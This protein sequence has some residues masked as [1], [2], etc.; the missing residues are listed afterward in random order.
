M[1]QMMTFEQNGIPK[2]HNVLWYD[3]ANGYWDEPAFFEDGDGLYS[4]GS[5]EPSA[6]LMRVWS[7]ELYGT[8]FNS[9]YDFGVTGDKL[10]IGSLFS[11]PSKQVAAFMSNG[12]TDGH[13]QL[14]V[15]SGSSLN[16]VSAFGVTS[17]IPVTN[18]T[19]TLPVPELPVYVELA[20]GQTI[21]VV[22]ENLGTD[23]ALQQGVSAT[24][25]GN[26]LSPINSSYPNSISKIYNGVLEDWYYNQGNGD[27]PWMDDTPTF[28]AWVQINLPSAQ[29]IS[30]VI[31]YSGVPWQQSGSL[32]DYYLQYLGANGQWV[33]L[34]HVT[35]PTPVEDFFSPPV[36]TTVDSY[37]SDRCVFQHD[38]PMVTTSAI[39]LLVNNTTYGGAATADIVAAGGQPG[40]HNI[41]L[42]EVE[43]Y[44]PGG[45]IAT[46]PASPT[47]LVATPGNVQV[48]LNWGTVNGATS[49]NVKRST[50]S[51]GPYA[52]I[53]SPTNS[54]FTDST[55]TNG[56]E[57]Y[58]VVSAVNTG[59]ESSNSS[60]VN[61]T[62]LQP[63]TSPTA[64]TGLTASAGNASV[65]LLWTPVTSANSYNVKRSTTNGGPYTT[66]ASPTSATFTDTSVTNGTTYYYVVSAVNTSGESNNSSPVNATPAAPIVK[67]SAPTGLSATAGNATVSLIW[68]SSAGAVTYNVKR[69][70]T[71][72]GP[73]TTISSPT[74]TTYA[75]NSVTNGIPRVKALTRLKLTL[76]QP[77]L[78]PEL[79]Y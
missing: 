46:P 61:A 71:T 75:D 16:V 66:I 54:T 26:G 56:A 17:T 77:L 6:A 33:N 52:T 12:L 22:P 29:Q 1:M 40:P 73:Y 4:Y 74:G 42:R 67:P 44:G 2:E 14:N 36:F 19:A 62:P 13:V 38:F 51:G 30:H 50:V 43:I 31:I 32:L 7:E 79:S 39:R 60:E 28:P 58:Y 35:E 3:V 76:P 70:N 63:A 64:P 65:S 78:Q 5:F 9:A 18:G 23:L 37:Y 45:I 68:N 49:Y 57:Y 25:S 15:S 69:S 53:A 34:S 21:S 20:Q 8:N 27:F 10:Y 11:G 72:G 47:G 59:G 48:S 41:T 55:V 24:S